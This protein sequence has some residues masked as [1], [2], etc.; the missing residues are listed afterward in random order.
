[1]L[2]REEALQVAIKYLGEQYLK[3]LSVSDIDDKLPEYAAIYRRKEINNC[4]IICVP[5]LPHESGRLDG[6]RVICISKD[7]GKILYDGSDGSG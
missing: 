6:G 1:M 3:L 7:T 5:A 2:T 4:W